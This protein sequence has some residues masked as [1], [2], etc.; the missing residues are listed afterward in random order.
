MCWGPTFTACSPPKSEPVKPVAIADGDYDPANWGKAWPLE[1][2][3][4][5]KTKDPKPTGKSRYKKGWDMDLVIYD[6]LSEFPYMA[7]L[8]NGWGFGVEYNEPRGHYYMVIDQLE[9]DPSRL[10]SGGVCLSCKTP[11]ADKLRQEL[12]SKYFADP[13]LEVHARIP[14][15]FQKLGVACL[16]CHN[17]KDMGL[18]ISKFAPTKAFKEIGLDPAHLSRQELRSAVCGQCH[19]TYIVS[20]DAD[21][22]S[23]DLFFPWRGGQAGRISIENIIKVLK[24]DPG[25]LEWKQNVTGYKVGF[26]RH[27]EYEFFTYNSVH[28]QANA[29]CADCHMP[30]TRVGA[31]KISDHDVT[32]PLKRDMKAC[33]QCHTETADWLREQVY[34]IQDRTVS[35]MNRAGYAVAVAAKIIEA[36]HK[37]QAEGKAID[38]NT[39]HRAKDLYLEALYRV[40]FI[41]AENSTGFH[42]PSEAGRIC[43]DAVALAGKAETLL[44]QALAKAG[45]DVPADVNL[46]LA[47]YLTNRGDKKLKFKPDQEL[48]DPFGLQELLTPVAS[49]GR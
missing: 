28:Y 5:L 40:I 22:K 4:W 38:G 11:Y 49:H 15:E 46:E 47:K 35:L 29:A 17:N 21:M 10:K 36:T 32:S 27:P 1:Y 16:D 14:K 26:I 31:N 3:Y 8:F 20:K 33:Q 6:K 30:Y 18:R 34:A 25:F 45:V 2:D 41:G 44:R 13:Y 48:K 9:V 42:N 37:A 23:K 12:G 19:V 7:L 43:G 39:Y 24:S